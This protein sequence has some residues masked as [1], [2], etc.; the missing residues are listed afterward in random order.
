MVIP[1]F[2]TLN[3]LNISVKYLKLHKSIPAS[4]SSKILIWGFLAI[5]VA[6][7]I[8]F[9]SPPDRDLFNSRSIY[10][11]AHK[12]TFDNIAQASFL[13]CHKLLIL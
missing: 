7:S 4:G 12:P 1:F 8:L 5:I 11:L 3:S 13:V 9:N 2:S 6:I 10:S